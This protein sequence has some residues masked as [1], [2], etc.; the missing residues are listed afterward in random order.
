MKQDKKKPEQL[1]DEA[2]QVA[3]YCKLCK[4]NFYNEISLRVA[5][6]KFLDM[7]HYIDNYSI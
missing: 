3:V 6:K 7:S 2:S 4:N 1:E 5:E